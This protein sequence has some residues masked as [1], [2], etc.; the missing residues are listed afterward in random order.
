MNSK[1]SVLERIDENTLL[2]IL[3]KLNN[4]PR[5]DVL[6]KD[7][8]EF[9]KYAA[10]KLTKEQALIILRGLNYQGKTIDDVAKEIKEKSGSELRSLFIKSLAN[11]KFRKEFRV[12]NRQVDLAYLL[13]NN[14][15]AVEVKANGDK[16]EAAKSQCDDYSKWA[17]YV[18]LLVEGKKE[19]ELSKA[20]LGD[21]VGVLV[22]NGTKFVELKKAKLLEHGLD[23]Y[24]NFMN[25][26]SLRNLAKSCGVKSDGTKESIAASIKLF[27][28]FQTILGRMEE[29]MLSMAKKYFMESQ[30]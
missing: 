11:V 2:Q 8:D 3:I 7:K 6:S 1:T 15:I 9:L 25:S 30:E 19:H 22:Y 17:N 28:K 13:N 27:S 10:S 18:Y 24:M 20:D 29:K 14:I 16:I 26:K 21:F 23:V 4:T 5:Y 12:G